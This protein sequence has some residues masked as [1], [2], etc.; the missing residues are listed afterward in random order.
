MTKLL[1]RFKIAW[2]AFRLKPFNLQIEPFK[3]HCDLIPN[4]GICDNKSAALLDNGVNCHNNAKVALSEVTCSFSIT[5][6][7]YYHVCEDCAK[8]FTGSKT[9]YKVTK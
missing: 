8:K 3:Y 7:N 6:G 9:K 5:I 1:L 2:L 4:A